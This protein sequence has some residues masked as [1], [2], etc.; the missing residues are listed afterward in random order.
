MPPERLGW[1]KQRPATFDFMILL[2]RSSEPFEK[3]FSHE[4]RVGPQ[5]K[6]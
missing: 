3:K 1:L 6:C 2:H 5:E 4:Q